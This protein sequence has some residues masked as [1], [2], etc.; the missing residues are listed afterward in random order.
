M[1][2][3]RLE[4]LGLVVDMARSHI[5]D[6]DSGLSD[7]TYDEADNLDL[8]AKQAA[9]EMVEEF[10]LIERLDLELRPC[11]AQDRETQG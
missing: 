5:E 3:E 1:K 4:A 8:A 6:I 10:L 9:L 2:Q 7:G 11:I